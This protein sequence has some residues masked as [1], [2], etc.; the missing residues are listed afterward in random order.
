MPSMAA[1]NRPLKRQFGD[2]TWVGSLICV[3]F[4]AALIFLAVHAGQRHNW[5]RL[6]GFTLVVLIVLSVPA[7]GLRRFGRVLKAPRAR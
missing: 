6:A 3:P 1:P 4:L 5:G 7:G 2:R